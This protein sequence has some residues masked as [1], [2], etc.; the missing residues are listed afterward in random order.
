MQPPPLFGRDRDKPL[1]QAPAGT[2]A[3]WSSQQQRVRA[4]R[5]GWREARAGRPSLGVPSWRRSSDP[6]TAGSRAKRWR[7]SDDAR[8]S[9]GT[10]RPCAW[11]R[12]GNVLPQAAPPENLTARVGLVGGLG[13]TLQIEKP[14]CDLEGA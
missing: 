7:W 5:L 2:G 12:R 8:G 3:R 13:P 10:Q 11:R 4:G 9:R 14:E 6:G 1:D